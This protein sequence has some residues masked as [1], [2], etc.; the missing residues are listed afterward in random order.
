MEDIEAE[1]ISDDI[2][3]HAVASLEVEETDCECYE[4]ARQGVRYESIHGISMMSLE[5]A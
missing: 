5:G 4:P 1:K 2:V 3:V